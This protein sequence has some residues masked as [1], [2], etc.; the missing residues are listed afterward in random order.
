M[1]AQVRGVAES[2]LGGLQIDSDW[3]SL[4]ADVDGLVPFEPLSSSLYGDV[5]WVAYLEENAE[6]ATLEE[7]H[8]SSASSSKGSSGALNVT[9]LLY[10]HQEKHPLRQQ[11]A[12]TISTYFGHVRAIRRM[13]KNGDDTALFLEDDVDIEWDV[14]RLWAHI[15]RR[16]PSH[17]EAV[18]LGHCWGREILSAWLEQESLRCRH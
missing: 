7:L 4:T 8:S 16:L 2:S 3:L 13:L 9:R 18:F 11:N 1:Q 14:Y 10:D 15:E 5:D 6:A 12:G 17:W